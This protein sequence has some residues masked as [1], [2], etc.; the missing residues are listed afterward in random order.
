VAYGSLQF[1]WSKCF[2]SH[3]YFSDWRM[4]QTTNFVIHPAKIA[5]NPITKIWHFL[6]QYVHIP[7]PGEEE[8]ISQWNLSLRG[9]LSL[10]LTNLIVYLSQEITATNRWS[11][12]IVEYGTHLWAE[13]YLM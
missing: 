13:H 5:Y 3:I 1:N 11:M 2:L 8:Q 4:D 12:A 9:V 10:N 6:C 7:S